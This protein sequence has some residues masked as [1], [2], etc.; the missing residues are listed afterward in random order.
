MYYE[1]V[2]CA[3]EERHFGKV[4]VWSLHSGDFGVGSEEAESA[5]NVQAWAGDGVVGDERQ[6]VGGVEAVI[7]DERDE[8]SAAKEGRSASSLETS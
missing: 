1:E 4:C 2:T 7:I 5:S 6:V 3:C 8:H